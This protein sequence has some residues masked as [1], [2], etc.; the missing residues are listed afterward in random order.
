MTYVALA[1]IT[2]SSNQ[3][4]V[5]FSSI[6]N[7]F[8]DLILVSRNSNTLA[9]QVINYRYN[10]DTG[11]NY[12]SVRMFNSGTTPVSDLNTPPELGY[13]NTQNTSVAQIFDYA[14]TDKHKISL[15]RWGNADGTSYVQA[16]STR[17]TNTAAIHT[18]FITTNG[19]QIAS[20]S[21]FALYGIR[22]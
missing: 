22:A 20:G 8:R 2:L 10:N 12:P 14:Q 15:T 18:I 21:T 16:Y 13:S 3:S 9:D 7:T 4:Q 1:N 6:P 11:A 17:W 19:G 5:T